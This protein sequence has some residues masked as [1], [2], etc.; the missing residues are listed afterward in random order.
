MVQKNLML[1]LLVTEISA[2]TMVYAGRSQATHGSCGPWFP[3]CN[4]WWHADVSPFSTASQ[5]WTHLATSQPIYINH[6][7]FFL[8][9]FLKKKLFIRKSTT[10]VEC[11]ALIIQLWCT[12]AAD[13]CQWWSHVY[14]HCGEVMGSLVVTLNKSFTS[15]NS[16]Y[17]CVAVGLWC[18]TFS[19]RV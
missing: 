8:Q 5:V 17:C 12:D 10:L 1:Q 19:P 11:K 14:N 13:T 16:P 7:N 4:F 15:N 3:S 18:V 9:S 6:F 2:F